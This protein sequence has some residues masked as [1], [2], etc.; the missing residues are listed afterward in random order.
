MALKQDFA[1]LIENQIAV[2]QE[3]IKDRQE[4]LSQVGA[5]A[6]ATYDKAVV[7]LR[8]NAEQGGELLLQVR[9]ANKGAWKD[10]RSSTQNGFEQLQKGWADA[11]KR[12]G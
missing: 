12:F 2:W 5:D 10:M 4:R 1:K 11:L 6:R 8:E 3:Q 7:G 9:Q